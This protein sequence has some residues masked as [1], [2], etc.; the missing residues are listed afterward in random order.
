MPYSRFTVT[1]IC[2]SVLVN[3]GRK[4]WSLYGY[5]VERGYPKSLKSL[6]LS[7]SVRKVN[8]AF[9]DQESGK[10]IFFVGDYYYRYLQHAIY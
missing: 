1:N 9:H 2:C 8:A 10:T 6:G 3:A 5:T 4:V 7:K